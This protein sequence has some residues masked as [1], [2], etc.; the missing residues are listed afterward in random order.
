MAEVIAASAGFDTDDLDAAPFT[1]RGGVDGI[2]RDLGHD[3]VTLI[4]QLNEELTA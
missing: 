4:D 3:A 1:E 2:V